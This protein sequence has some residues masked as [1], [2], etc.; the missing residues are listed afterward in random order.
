MQQVKCC[1]KANTHRDSKGVQA[2]NQTFTAV[3]PKF[4]EIN[5]QACQKHDIQQPCSTRQNDATVPLQQIDAV[6]PNDG[7]GYDQSQ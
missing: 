7:P 5:L 6:R 1:P 4:I 2:K 3:F